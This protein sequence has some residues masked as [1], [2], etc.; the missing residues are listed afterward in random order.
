MLRMMMV[1]M[2]LVSRITG[3]LGELSWEG[4][5]EGP[6]IHYDF[7]TQKTTAVRWGERS[8]P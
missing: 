7:L 8:F 5:A 1:R 4:K 3:S 6:I 2:R